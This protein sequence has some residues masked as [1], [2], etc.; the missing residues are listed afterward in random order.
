MIT[1]LEQ[2]VLLKANYYVLLASSI[3]TIWVCAR[4]RGHIKT[5]VAQ[6]ELEEMKMYV[7]TVKMFRFTLGRRQY[8]ICSCEFCVILL[9]VAFR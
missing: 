8:R 2:W 7:L 3:S 4:K 6:S 5:N 9:M 1:I